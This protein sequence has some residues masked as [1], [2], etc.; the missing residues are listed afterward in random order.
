MHCDV[1]L[2]EKPLALASYSDGS[3]VDTAI[4]FVHGFEGDPEKTWRDFIFLINTQPAKFSWY[5]KADL[6]F[7]GYS[8]FR[9]TVPFNAQ[10]CFRFISQVFP[11]VALNDFR[12]VPS[13]D[14]GW[15]TRA[16]QEKGIEKVLEKRHYSHLVLVGHSEG[17]SYSGLEC[18]R[19]SRKLLRAFRNLDS[20]RPPTLFL[21]Q[22]R[23]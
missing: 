19:S 21:A 14:V 7:Y 11:K 13:V 9:K 23:Y 5:S 20:N 16:I 15:I 8:N 22:T 1:Q 18:G 3:D 6:F 10:E 12:A 17:G 4:V 2:R